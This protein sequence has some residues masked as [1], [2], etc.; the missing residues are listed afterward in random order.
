[1]GAEA[2]Q[3]ARSLE[4]RDPLHIYRP[5]MVLKTTPGAVTPTL[6]HPRAPSVFVFCGADHHRNVWEVSPGS[7]T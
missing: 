3:D 1:M 5:W 7:N 2:C 4:V 6:L